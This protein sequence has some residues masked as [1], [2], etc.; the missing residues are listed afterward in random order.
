MGTTA[1]IWGS[2]S[3]RM[4]TGVRVRW[5]DISAGTTSSH[6]Y[7]DFFVQSV[8]WSYSDNQRLSVSG[9]VSGGWNYFAD[10]STNETYQVGTIDL[11]VKATSYSGGPSW[12]LIGTVSG[13]YDGSSPTVD[14]TFTLPARPASAPGAPSCT[15]D[16]VT[17]SS[18]RVVVGAAAANGSSVIEYQGQVATSSAFT[19]V[20]LVWSGGTRTVTGLSASSTYYA[21]VRA[22]NSIGWGPWSAIRSFTTGAIAPSAPTGLAIGSITPDSATATWTDGSNGGSA[23][24]GHDIQVARDSGFSVGLLTFDADASPFSITGL[25]AGTVYYARVRAVNGIGPSQYSTAVTFTTLVGTPV[26]ASPAQGSSVSNGYASFS[27]QA[28][29]MSTEKTITVEVTKDVSFSTGVITL[30]LTPTTASPTSL[31]TVESLS[32]YLSNGTWYA[33]SKISNVS[34]GYVTP[35]SDVISFVQSHAPSV[36]ALYPL[37]GAKSKFI[38]PFTFSWN[39][40]D[41]AGSVDAQTAY[42]LV[43]E[44]NATGEIVYDSGKVALTAPI[45]TKIDVSVAIDASYKSTVLRWRVRAWD[46]GDNVSSWTGYNLFTLSD[47]PVVIVITPASGLTVDTGAPTFWWSVSIPSVGTQASSYLRII[48]SDDNSL[49]WE[50]YTHGAS[51]TVTPPVVILRNSKDYYYTLTVTDSNGLSTVVSDSFS[52]SYSAPTPI[53]YF[54]EIDGV[55]VNGYARV[56]WRDANPDSLFVSWKVYRRGAAS[57]EWEL[58]TEITDQNIRK[59]DDYL[60][61]AGSSYSYSVTQTAVRSGVLLESPVGYYLFEEDQ[62]QEAR[63]YHADIQT[64]WL[65]DAENTSSSV[66]LPGV[67]NDDS[68]LEYEMS[69]YTIIGRGRHTDYGDRLGYSGSI[70]CQVRAVERPSSLRIK[71]EDMLD[72]KSTYYLR[73][74]FGRTFKVTL[75]NLGWSPIAGVGTSEMGDMTIQYTEVS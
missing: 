55:D 17:G 32:A 35:W 20:I 51:T 3:G 72:R 13:A 2:K 70:T 14:Y 34:T 30:A 63:I 36:V 65:I 69:T 64:F 54:V 74:P 60:L 49:V 66:R 12:R 23:I 26:I 52:T 58:L 73:T 56:N 45:N 48:D 25:S 62:Q 38:S 46:K 33:R 29:G 4:R 24:N 16:S 15:V 1:I 41:S 47:P 39:V 43:V 22:R 67:I 6:V 59:Y 57:E 10:L 11:G 71:I 50:K 40:Q 42:Q 44:N 31:Y 19:S 28:Y 61:V 5:D 75:G 18:A 9:T 68:T 53:S 21:R 27:V 37:A 8:D 7:A